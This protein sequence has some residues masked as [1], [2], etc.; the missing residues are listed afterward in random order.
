[1]WSQLELAHAGLAAAVTCIGYAWKGLIT[2]SELRPLICRAGGL[3]SRIFTLGLFLW[4]ISSCISSLHPLICVIG[5]C[6]SSPWKSERDRD[7]DRDDSSYVMLHQRNVK[8]FTWIHVMTCS[9]SRCCAS[10]YIWKLVGYWLTAC[11]ILLSYRN[12][13]SSDILAV[14]G[15]CTQK[16]VTRM[17][18]PR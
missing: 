16:L 10:Q 5:D 11:G 13:L 12:A 14:C 17:S 9:I 15:N 6:S 4:W 1:M 18:H 8:W 2:H 3:G 7:R